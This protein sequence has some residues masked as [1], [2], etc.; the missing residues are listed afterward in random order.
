[1]KDT[2]RAV[3]LLQLAVSDGLRH[4]FFADQRVCR[5]CHGERLAECWFGRTPLLQVL[6]VWCVVFA[7]VVCAGGGQCNLDRGNRGEV[8]R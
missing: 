8:W 5:A 7:T 2:G 4:F 6:E 1:M 3:V